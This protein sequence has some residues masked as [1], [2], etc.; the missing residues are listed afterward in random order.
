MGGKRGLTEGVTFGQV[1]KEMREGAEGPSIWEGASRQSKG[2]DCVVWPGA[3]P[4]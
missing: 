4:P 3:S 2:S 1:V